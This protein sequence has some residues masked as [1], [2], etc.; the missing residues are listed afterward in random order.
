ME[1]GYTDILRT[2]C[3]NTSEL[4]WEY[5]SIYA[6]KSNTTTLSRFIV[7]KFAPRFRIISIWRYLSCSMPNEKQVVWCR[8]V[9]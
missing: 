5:E 7:R 3:S 8:N 4:D 1:G 2:L 9:S 6:H